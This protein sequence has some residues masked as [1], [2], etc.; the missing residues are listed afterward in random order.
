MNC[1]RQAIG[2]TLEHAYAHHIQRLMVTGNFALLAGIAPAA[3]CDW[4]LAVYMDAFDWVELPNVLGMVLHADGGYL[5]SKP[6]CA[7]GQY[8]KRMSDYCQGCAYQVSESTTGDACPFNALYWHFLMRH[9][10]RLQG[11]PRMGMVYKN[12]ARMDEAKR[13]ALW[14]RGEALLARLDAGEAL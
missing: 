13:Q 7:S 6:Y 2:Q 5:G 8:I 9:R 3:L 14:R 12:L 10:E 1:L 11:N 4:Y